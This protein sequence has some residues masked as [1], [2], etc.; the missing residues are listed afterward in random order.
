MA[1]QNNAILG[2]PATL[3]VPKQYR[4]SPFPWIH[5]PRGEE[6]LA[7][8][9]TARLPHTLQDYG[10]P[11]ERTLQRYSIVSCRWKDADDDSIISFLKLFFSLF[12]DEIGQTLFDVQILIPQRKGNAC[13]LLLKT[14]SLDT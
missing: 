2:S 10:T 3:L 13:S 1:W 6:R 14:F 11:L 9:T 12:S 5:Q 4:H 7:A 8:W